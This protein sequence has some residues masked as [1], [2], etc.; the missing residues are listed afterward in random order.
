MNGN[1]YVK[2]IPNEGSTFFVELFNIDKPA[3]ELLPEKKIHYLILLNIH[4]ENKN[5]L[6]VDD[7]ESNRLLLK[8]FLNKV[9]LTCIYC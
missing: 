7:V 3:L 6:V 1:I 5:I 4:F 2:S 9:G 8:E